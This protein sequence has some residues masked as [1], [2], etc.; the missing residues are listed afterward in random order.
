MGS[1]VMDASQTLGRAK[2][3]GGCGHCKLLGPLE[4]KAWT[5]S[6]ETSSTPLWA[7]D[8]RGHSRPLQ[9]LSGLCCS[10]PLTLTGLGTW[11]FPF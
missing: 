4:K 7:E 3:P 6:L 8:I 11:P 5:L 10:L 1:E 9:P 2:G